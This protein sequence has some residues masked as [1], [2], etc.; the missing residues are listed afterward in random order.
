MYGSG[1]IYL[2]LVLAYDNVVKTYLYSDS[3]TTWLKFTWMVCHNFDSKPSFYVGLHHT[4]AILE[5]N[6]ESISKIQNMKLCIATQAINFFT[7]KITNSVSQWP[8]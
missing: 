6:V 7:D 1:S 3:L 4:L 5:T 2:Y 8:I